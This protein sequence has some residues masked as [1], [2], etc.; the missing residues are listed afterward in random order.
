[1][2]L[3]MA[4]LASCPPLSHPRPGAQLCLCE[5][6]A[7]RGGMRRVWIRGAIIVNRVSR[8]QEAWL[9]QDCSKVGGS[10]DHV[11]N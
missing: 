6:P 8:D 5:T 7:R 3:H 2:A 9:F 4:Q 10:M 11:P 1:M